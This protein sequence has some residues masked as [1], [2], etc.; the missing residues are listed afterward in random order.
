M[1]SFNTR[2][3]T[4]RLSFL[5]PTSIYIDDQETKLPCE[6]ISIECNYEYIIPQEAVEGNEYVS[7]NIA[8][9]PNVFKVEVYVHN[10]DVET[11]YLDMMDAQYGEHGFTVVDR[12]GAEYINL[13]LTNIT[14][15]Q[16]SDRG[17]CEF[18]TLDFVEMNIV[19]ALKIK[20]YSL[21]TPPA[22]T[23]T[24]AG[25]TVSAVETAASE[26]SGFDKFF[27]VLECGFKAWKD[28]QTIIQCAKFDTLFK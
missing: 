11:F 17:G 28:K 8:R 2:T 13:R 19:S 9:K 20:G 27:K 21:D 25:G 6:V 18:F 3:I 24:V 10:D 26:F 16:D 4:Q 15:A 14:N 1:I 22:I 7:D 23:P 5:H 12:N